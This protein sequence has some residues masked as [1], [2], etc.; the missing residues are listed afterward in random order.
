MPPG[1]PQKPGTLTPSQLKYDFN[2]IGRSVQ[3]LQILTDLSQWNDLR[4]FTGAELAP[5]SPS[6]LLK[7]QGLIATLKIP[8]PSSGVA[9]AVRS[10]LLSMNFEVQSTSL[11]CYA[12]S[13][14]IP[15]SWRSKDL[16]DL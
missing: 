1:K 12:G 14:D 3:L 2:V 4:A 11:I 5:V 6:A 7:K 10:M 15:L 13:I 16:P 9:I 8:A